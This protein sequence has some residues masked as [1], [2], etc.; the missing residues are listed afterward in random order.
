MW[1]YDYYNMIY[2]AAGVLTIVMGYLYFVVE[3]DELKGLVMMQ[4]AL[5]IVLL[6][7]SMWFRRNLHVKQR[8]RVLEKFENE[9][10]RRARE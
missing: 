1:G 5:S 6:F 2:T 7:A 9:K 10:E 4:G 3:D 8:Q